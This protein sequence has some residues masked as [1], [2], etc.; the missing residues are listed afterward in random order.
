MSTRPYVLLSCAMS[1]DGYIDDSTSKRLVLSNEADLDRVDEV[2][3]SCDAILIG[4][5]TIRRDNPRL[6]VN[7]DAR[8]AE[9][10]SHG[11]PPYPAKVTITRAGLDPAFKFFNTGGEKI[12]YC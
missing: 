11:L 8:R 1:I 5:N 7:S 10:V 2:R 9:R 3:A 6:L 12:V 4:A